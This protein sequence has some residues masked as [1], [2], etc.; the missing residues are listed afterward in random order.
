MSAITGNLECPAA[1]SILSSPTVPEEMLWKGLQRIKRASTR[2]SKKETGMDRYPI[3]S[4]LMSN[5]EPVWDAII[6]EKPYPV[7]AVG[8]FGWQCHWSPLRTR[9]MSGRLFQRWISC[10]RPIFYHTPT[11]ALADVI[12]LCSLGGK[13]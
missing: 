10:L 5:P 6:E 9:E 2:A 12:L 11:T 4:R 8:L 7:K 1:M 3:V 13:G